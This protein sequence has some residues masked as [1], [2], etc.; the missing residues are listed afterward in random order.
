MEQKIYSAAEAKSN[1]AMIDMIYIYNDAEAL[2]VSPSSGTAP[3]AY[4]DIQTWAV[5]NETLFQATS[6]TPS[7]FDK[8]TGDPEIFL[9]YDGA[10]GFAKEISKPLTNNSV[11]GFKTKNDKKGLIKITNITTGVNG[12]ITFDVKVQK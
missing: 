2:F 8:I 11:I 9:A 7:E 4:S 3:Q 5:K 10:S 12:S 6:V 1:P